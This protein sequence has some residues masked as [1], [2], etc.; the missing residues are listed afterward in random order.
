MLQGRSVIIVEDEPIIALCL[1]MEV[2]HLN[3]IVVGPAST[4][5]QALSLLATTE[6]SAGLLDANLQDRDITPVALLLSRR[7]IP[8]VIHSA[9]GIPAEL[10]LALPELSFIPKPA[11]AS[12]VVSCLRNKCTAQGENG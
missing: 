1:A 8:F 2:E 11:P 6:V 7:R 9:I 10:A 5:S 3:G 12:L 4:V